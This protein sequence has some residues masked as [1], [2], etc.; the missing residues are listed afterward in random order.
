MSNQD[1]PQITTVIPTFRRPA[2]LRRAMLSVLEQDY[3]AFQLYVYDNASGDE[4]AEVVAEL[5]RNDSRVRYHC[6]DQN[7]GGL[8]NFQYGLARVDT[9]YFSFLSDDD[10]LLPGFFRK[11]V[12]SL[13]AS[14]EAI[15]WAGLTLR[16]DSQGGFFDARLDKWEREGLFSPPDGVL[17][18]LHG[19]APCWAGTLFR[20]QAIDE[21]GLLDEQVGGPADLDYMLRAAARHPYIVSKAP[22]AVYTMNPTS[23]SETAPLS[24]FWPGWLK[25]IE[26]IRD[27]L[28]ADAREQIVEALHADASRMLFRRGAGALAKGKDGYEFARQSAQALQQQYRMAARSFLLL[29]I[30]GVCERAPV[31]QRIYTAAYRAAERRIVRQRSALQAKYAG[32]ERPL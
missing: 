1:Q 22:V 32:F 7:I 2:L 3:S 20:R 27:A 19:D 17:R 14:R 18:M 30:A 13:D 10:Y 25:M 16:L 11:S 4:T 28:P 9:P 15:F 31:L 21:I 6:H 8:A 12:V 5:A 23:F 24:V 26:N 29:A